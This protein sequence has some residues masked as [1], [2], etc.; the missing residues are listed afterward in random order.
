MLKAL[1][2][3]E[4]KRLEAVW[5]NAWSWG[6]SKEGA[7]KSAPLCLCSEWSIGRIDASS[8][9]ICMLRCQVE[10]GMRRI[11][12]R[13][14]RSTSLVELVTLGR[15]NGLSRGSSR[16]GEEIN[17]LL[18]LRLPWS[19]KWVEWIDASYVAAWV[20]WM[21]RVEFAIASLLVG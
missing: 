8:S 9:P 5:V 16:R 7:V 11:R 2:S 15:V 19:S 3:L 21:G 1:D 13:F 17:L 18:L 14:D 6:S 20:E 4:V 12:R 10:W